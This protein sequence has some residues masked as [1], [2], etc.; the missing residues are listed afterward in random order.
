M[1][2]PSVWLMLIAQKLIPLAKDVNRRS[3]GVR[4]LGGRCGEPALSALSARGADRATGGAD[5]AD[6]VVAR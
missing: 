2:C 6:S 1:L 3:A 4:G 5:A